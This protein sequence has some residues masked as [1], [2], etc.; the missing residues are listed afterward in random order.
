M[1]ARVREEGN[2]SEKRQGEKEADE[3][4]E[5]EAAPGRTVGSLRRFRAVLIGPSQELAKQHRLRR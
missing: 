4:D 5:V 2:A 3:A 1:T